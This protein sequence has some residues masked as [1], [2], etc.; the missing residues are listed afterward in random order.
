LFL[1][2]ID[3][4]GDLRIWGNG[5]AGTQTWMPSGPI[6][7]PFIGTPSGGGDF[8]LAIR[9]DGSVYA[10]GRSN[11]TGV[12]TVP[13]DGPFSAVSA[14]HRHAA[15]LRRNGSIVGWG[16]PTDPWTGTSV[17]T[18]PSG[19]PFVQ[20]ACGDFNIHAIRAD[21]TIGSAGY[22]GDGATSCPS[23]GGFRKVAAGWGHA[24]SLR[25]DGSIAAWGRNV[26]G[27]CNVPAGAYVD[28]AA[29]GATSCALRSDGGV[30]V[31]GVCSDGV[32]QV[33]SPLPNV[34]AIFANRGCAG[35]IL[36]DPISILGVRPISGPSSG[37]TSV[38]IT[39]VNFKPG[40]QV[41][42]DGVPA[43][44]VQVLSTTTITATTPGGFPGEALVTVDYGSATAF[45][46]RPECGSDL[47][48]DGQVGGGDMAIL[49]L[50]WGAC[51]SGLQANRS[52]EPPEL[53][54]D[55]PFPSHTAGVSR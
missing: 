22:A 54:A 14:G 25:E 47:D 3:T 42:F 39:G 43:T 20:L 33:P 37:G 13:T 19:G 38:T 23:S 16:Y 2:G 27:E 17:T 4:T 10:I 6:A 18:P 55:E 9:T 52:P 8:V 24:I 15:A 1:A 53:L 26:Q 31:W 48:Q 34:G 35:V 50:D 36:R 32:C 41:A 11:E 5:E 51:Y 45:Y 49:L 40:A 7:G 29:G 21:G 44:N 46:Y 28:I 12:L 30:V